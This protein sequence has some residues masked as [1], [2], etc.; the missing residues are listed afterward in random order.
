M[1]HMQ[2]TV[3]ILGSRGMQIYLAMMSSTTLP[4][5][6]P[7]TS[8]ST[9]TARRSTSTLPNSTPTAP[10]A[11]PTTLTTPTPSSRKSTPPESP[12]PIPELTESSSMPFQSPTFIAFNDK[13]HY[14]PYY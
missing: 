8:K 2:I 11:E 1:T 6:H 5:S 12:R 14:R 9:R 7:A 4:K 13:I 3:Q 10:A